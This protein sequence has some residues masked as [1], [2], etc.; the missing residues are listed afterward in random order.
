VHFGCDTAFIAK[1]K[2]SEKREMQ[3]RTFVAAA[4]ATLAV[5]A[6]AR[7]QQSKE[8]TMSELEHVNPDGMLKSPVFS[9]GIVYPAG[10]RILI[11]GG[12][13]GVDETGKVVAADLAGQTARAVDN[14]IK[15][16]ETAG[17]TIENLVRVGLYVKGADTDIQP[18]FEAWLAK[19][20]ERP[21]PPTVT[22]V[23]VAGLVMPDVLIEIEGTAVL[24]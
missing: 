23:R 14:L 1:P 6:I 17:G 3:R 4:V 11:I 12:Q 18:G 21:N 19:W 8:L 10:S 7:D 22:M 5:P 2:Q 24:P 16:V 9:Q 15:V 13:D 20:G